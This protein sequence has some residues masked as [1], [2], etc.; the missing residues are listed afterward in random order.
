MLSRR[1]TSPNHEP[2]GCACCRSCAPRRSQPSIGSRTCGGPRACGGSRPR[3]HSQPCDESQT[4]GGP[5]WGHPAALPY[6]PCPVSRW[7][8][9]AGLNG[10]GT[11]TPAERAVSGRIERFWT[12]FP[13]L[14]VP[15]PCDTAA[16]R[17]PGGCAGPKTVQ[18]GRELPAGRRGEG[19]TWPAW[20]PRPLRPACLRSPPGESCRCGDGPC[21][22][23]RTS[24]WSRGHHRPHP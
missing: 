23:L 1:R 12:R 24:P 21:P 8:F 19:P 17:S 9:A 20:R 2:S 5:A 22:P 16:K 13:S 18:S 6:R 11:S 15:K 14:T 4:C 10:F 7:Q 3:N